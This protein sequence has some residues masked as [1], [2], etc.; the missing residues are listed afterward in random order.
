M[1]KFKK[2]W[3]TTKGRGASRSD[4]PVFQPKRNPVQQRRVK[5]H[6]ARGF[7]PSRSEVVESGVALH[8]RSVVVMFALTL[9]FAG[10]GGRLAFVGLM[11]PAEPRASI[12]EMPKETLRRGNIYDRNE[13]L[14]AATLKVYSLYADPKRIL[15]PN[16]VIRKLPN[17]LPDLDMVRLRGQLE[18]PSRRFIWIKRRLTPDEAQRV[19]AL[20]LPGLEFRE[21]FVR[22]YPH[23]SLASHILGAVDVDNTGLAGVERS[24]D[25]QLG[26]GEDVRLGLD[27]RLQEM[28]RSRLQDMLVKSE[29]KAAWGLVMKAPTREIVAMVSLPDFDPNHLGKARPEQRFNHVTLGSYEM[30]STFKLFT[31]AQGL[32]E[33]KI[34]PD[35]LIDCRVPITIGRFTIKDYHAKKSV[36][37]ANEVL[38]YSSNIGAAKIADMSGPAAQKDF[39]G[40]L[41]FLEPM[42]IGVSE[43]GNVR[44]PSNW[45]RIQSFTISFGHGMSVTPVHLVNAV[46]T[47]SDGYVKPASVL[48][49]GVSSTNAVRMID[50]ATLEQIHVLMRDVVLNG[51]GRSS[52]VVGYDIGGKTG[53]AEKISGRGYSKDK[54]LVSYV[55]VLPMKNPEYITLVM[56]DEPKKGYE[57]GGKSAAPVVGQFYRD[58]TQLAGLKP[59]MGEVE[60]YKAMLEKTKRKVDDPWNVYALSELRTRR[61]S[62]GGVA[63]RPQDAD[64]GGAD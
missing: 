59:D 32:I 28:L 35:T 54:N 2:P 61:G 33:K 23:R 39:M 27:V 58:M 30:G 63:L 6:A 43:V 47:L 25:K 17:A 53:T 60:A 19:N 14:L 56:I 1:S 41:G 15:D 22:V 44:Y 52:A 12:R 18:D 8:F 4:A 51:S 46:A 7:I 29:G 11:P 49:G 45:G 21:E 24:F 57:T 3:E 62:A 20:G 42:N 64:T 36:L 16:E 34:T 48:K 10:V 26:A 50:D 31:L 9:A 37:T 13:V 40:K 55:G 5:T 38:R